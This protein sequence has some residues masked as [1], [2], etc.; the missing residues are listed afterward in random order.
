[1]TRVGREKNGPK[2]HLY[3]TL[4]LFADMRESEGIETKKKMKYSLEVGHEHVP[5][6]RVFLIYHCQGKHE[7]VD[8]DE[9]GV[10][11]EVGDDIEGGGGS[12]T[13]QSRG[14][15]NRDTVVAGAQPRVK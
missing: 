3:G 7:E 9:G 15:V 10:G 6:T 13:P 1:M 5:M 14:Q 2:R 11:V 12:Y 4:T 8:E